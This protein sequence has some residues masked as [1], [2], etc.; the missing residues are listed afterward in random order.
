[1]VYFLRSLFIVISFFIISQAHAQQNENILINK[2]G[3]TI[4]LQAISSLNINAKLEEANTNFKKYNEVLKP[5]PQVNNLD[6][7][8]SSA[9]EYLQ[10]NTEK[11]YST[12]EFTIRGLEDYKREWLGYDKELDKWQ[13]LLA[14]RISEVDLNLFKLNVDIITWQLTSKKSR[15]EGLPKEL[16]DNA[17]ESIL[18]LLL[19]HHL[20]PVPF[21]EILY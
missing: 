9:G 6:S 5:H 3:D 15:E 10:D 16:L 19:F 1:M 17:N 21:F 14:N 2:A 12:E 18:Y 11:I 4:Y 8:I 20:D 7:L 13:T